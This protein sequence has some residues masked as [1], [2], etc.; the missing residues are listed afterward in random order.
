M[1]RPLVVALNPSVDVEWN[2][3]R[4]R[5]EEKNEVL[6]E[7]RWPGGKGVNVARWLKHLGCPARLLVPLGGATGR[8]MIAGLRREG[9]KA[10]VVPLRESTRA[11]VIVSA[12]IQGQ[13]RFNPL[14][15]EVRATEWRACLR[16]IGAELRSASVVVLS[17]S[18]PRGVPVDAYAR[19]IRMARKARV[20]AVLDCDGPRLAAGVTARPFL[21]KPNQHELEQWAG[22]QLASLTDVTKAA[23]ELSS[24]T[25]GWVLVSMG[26]L[27]GLLVHAGDCVGLRASGPRVNPV[28]T[29]GAGDALLAT[30][31]EQIHRGAPPIEWLRNGVATGGAA[32]TCPAGQLPSLAGIRA[33]VRR[34]KVS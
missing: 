7:R 13:L 24:V 29:V 31:V 10:I 21:V 25:S 28:N 15:P 9:L 34:V 17:G 23:S 5:W 1:K 16:R 30:V 4:V 19:L 22:R 27:G 32:T 18:L 2:V 12:D 6:S 20:P 14:G 3:R 33:S 11:N 8:E 26:K